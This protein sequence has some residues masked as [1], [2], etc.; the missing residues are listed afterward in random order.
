M[1]GSSPTK[2]AERSASLIEATA[3]G[4]WR[5]YSNKL[6]A[7][8]SLQATTELVPNQVPKFLK[9][10]ALPRTN[11]ERDPG[12]MDRLRQR[13][14]LSSRKIFKVI[15]SVRDGIAVV[16]PA[17]CQSRFN[18]SISRSLLVE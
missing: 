12:G 11:L 3:P 2:P 9:R 1:C 18:K 5:A 7:S 14:L 15:D 10:T 8:A 4:Q 6:R 17:L 13:K 16:R